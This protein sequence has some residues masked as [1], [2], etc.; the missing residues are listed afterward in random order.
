MHSRPME[1]VILGCNECVRQ[2]SISPSVFS[3]QIENEIVPNLVTLKENIFLHSTGGET[4][5][6]SVLKL[7]NLMPTN[8]VKPFTL[9]LV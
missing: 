3:K 9:R 4:Y 7:F 8:S 6:F 2:F 5:K 1:E